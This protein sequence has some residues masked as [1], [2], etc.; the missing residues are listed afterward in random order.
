MIRLFGIT[1]YMV[2]ATLEGALFNV[3]RYV[4]GKQVAYGEF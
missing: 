4:D 3:V 1:G 2:V